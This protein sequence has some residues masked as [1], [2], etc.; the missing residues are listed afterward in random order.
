MTGRYAGRLAVGD[1]AALE[2]QP[3]LGAVRV[4][5]LAEQARLADAGLADHRHDLAA[6]RPGLLQRLAQLLHL[7]V[8][9][10]EAREPARRAR[11]A[12]AIRTGAAPV[13][14]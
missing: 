8:A 2:D 3:A 10:D 5:E 14:S 11:P 12:A 6:P 9:P 7:R 1:G 4:R 13:T